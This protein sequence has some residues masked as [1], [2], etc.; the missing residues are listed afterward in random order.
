MLKYY[1]KRFTIKNFNR[2]FDFETIVD[3]NVTSYYAMDSAANTIVKFNEIWEFLSNKTLAGYYIKLVDNEFF[4][5]VDSGIVKTDKDLN[6]I[7][8]FSS[9]NYYRGLYYNE[10]SKNIFVARWSAYIIEKFDLN[11]T[12][13]DSISTGSN[14]PYGLNG[15][16]NELFVGTANGQ[17]LVIQNKTITKV[18][19]TLCSGE[20]TSSFLFDNNGYIS[21]QCYAGIAGSH[22]YH[23]NGTYMNISLPTATSN[24]GM[25]IDSKGRLIATS[26]NELNIFY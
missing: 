2:L 20:R 10:T 25:K 22:I 4:L 26:A 8:T 14:D 5:S 18:Y 24:F 17:I 6:I 13:L 21:I 9:G 16:K 7:K 1:Q 12:L 19:N 15:Y 23:I 11:L 3:N